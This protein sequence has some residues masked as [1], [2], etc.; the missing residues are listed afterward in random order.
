MTTTAVVLLGVIA[1][2][3]LVMAAI[4]IAMAVH[5]S[6]L[7]RRVDALGRQLEQDIRPLVTRAATVAEN[8]AR[9]TSLA[10]A[11]VERA[12]RLLAGLSGRVEE[13]AAV[14]QGTLLAPARE[15]RALLAGLGATIGAFRELRQAD[16]ARA[17]RR[18]DDDPLF[19]G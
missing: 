3:T 2:S 8:A 15:G 6:R 1:A 10:V 13:T 19:I 14:I 9:A 12:D 18:D 11:Q 16:R 17:A 7:A 5:A 4:Q